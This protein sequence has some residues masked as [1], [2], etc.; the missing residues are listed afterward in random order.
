[1]IDIT[2]NSDNLINEYINATENYEK[3][4][5]QQ[6]HEYPNGRYLYD[7]TPYNELRSYINCQKAE[8]QMM[9]MSY[10]FGDIDLDKIAR[11]V[12]KW[13]KRNNYQYCL[14]SGME[15]KLLQFFTT[16]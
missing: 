3:A 13:D 6:K 10:V 16:A 2:V 11:V 5:R 12:R 15:D 9:S 1:M 8:A 7:K 4:F 14:S